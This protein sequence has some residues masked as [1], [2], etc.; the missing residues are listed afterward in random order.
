VPGGVV[1]GVP[2]GVPGGVIGGGASSP[3]GPGGLRS[4]FPPRPPSPPARLFAPVV[5]PPF[6]ATGP[7]IGGGEA[8]KGCERSL[9]GCRDPGST[10]TSPAGRYE[11]L[12]KQAR[13]TLL[14][15]Q[16]AGTGDL[17]DSITQATEAARLAPDQPLAWALLGLLHLEARRFDEAGPLLQRAAALS[18]VP[19]PP[20]TVQPE[21]ARESAAELS[22]ST[23]PRASL[24]D[25]PL[26]LQVQLGLVLLQAQRGEL[27]QAEEQARRLLQRRGLS[28][29]VLYRL[30]DLLMAR[31]RLE[32]ATALYGRACRMP[33]Q[34]GGLAVEVSRS[35]FAFAV[36]LERGQRTEVLSALQRATQHDRERRALSM[37]DFFPSHDRDFYRALAGPPSSPVTSLVQ[38]PPLLACARA[39]ALTEYLAQARERPDTP[40]SYL[41]R[42]EQQLEG[43]GG[44]PCAASVK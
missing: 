15:V 30:G 19:P 25:A 36:A 39:Q 13:D 41:R 18:V 31:G 20:P 24:L 21:P 43:L 11:H 9:W 6:S 29:R 27:V 17:G 14:T 5:E 3:V 44:L 40:P 4:P 12:C 23:A 1:G 16:V 26:D 38:Q 8:G 42:A 37:P 34:A 28:H 35:C 2:G 32:E 7:G 33:R 10:L 22:S